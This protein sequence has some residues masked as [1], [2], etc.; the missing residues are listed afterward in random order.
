MDTVILAV[1]QLET[2]TGGSRCGVGM[3]NVGGTA[4]YS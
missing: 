4:V 2:T 3:V 1:E